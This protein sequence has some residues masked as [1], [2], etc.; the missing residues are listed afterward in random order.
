MHRAG[1]VHR[2]VKPGNVMIAPGGRVVLMDFGLV[3]PHADRLGHR[4]TAGSMQYMA[5]E[6]LRG[7]VVEG[8][9]PLLDVYALGVLAYELL[10]GIIPFDGEEVRDL[11]RAKVRKP[12]PSVASRRSDVP[13]ALG[14]LIAQLMAPDSQERPPGVEAALWQ[15]AALRAAVGASPE[16]RPFTVLIV[17]DDEDMRRALALYVRAAAGDVMIETA[18]EGRG[19]IRA[20]RRRVP[21][22]LL[23]DLDLPDINGLEVIMLL[24]GMQIGDACSIVSVSGRASPADVELLQQLGVRSLMK[25]PL[26]MTQL[27]EIVQGLVS[28][29]AVGSAR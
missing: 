1:L 13:P 9:A 19:A 27:G 29:R 28:T 23:V 6:A 12:V 2:D 16:A 11:Y 20:V 26:L 5:P 22:L 25:G 15:L 7:R 8:T 3:L 4:T 18:G 21:N 17:D 10:C 14:D 24:R